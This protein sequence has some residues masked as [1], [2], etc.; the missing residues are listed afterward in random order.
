MQS[1]DVLLS[2]RS[3]GPKHLRAPAP[4]PDEVKLAIRAALRTPDHQ[5]LRPFRFVL[6]EGA[7]L[8]RLAELFVDYGRRHGKSE[9]ELADER[10]RATQAPLV[11]AIIGALRPDP[12]VPD[13]EQWMA[14]GGAVA[15]LLMAFHALGFGAKMLSGR[16]AAD[17]QLAAAFCS[18]GERLVGWV[19]VG[20]VAPGVTPRQSDDDVETVVRVL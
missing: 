15:N 19:S 1:I 2:R 7:G 8:E 5:R 17:P 18:P 6:V 12:D 16:R 3:V 4:S 14:V 9:A 20:T 11:I 10:T 13:H